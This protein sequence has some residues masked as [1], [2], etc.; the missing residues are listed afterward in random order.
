MSEVT[1]EEAIMAVARIQAWMD[2]KRD[3][4]ILNVAKLKTL[5]TDHYHDAG[6]TWSQLIDYD[7]RLAA[8]GKRSD[9]VVIDEA[10]SPAP[11]V[12]D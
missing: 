7:K 5:L 10:T 1:P 6:K 2:G 8:R 4:D 3:S 9:L 11:S 12:R